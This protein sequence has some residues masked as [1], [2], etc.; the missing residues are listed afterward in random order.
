MMHL[1]LGE[2]GHVLD[3]GLAQVGAVAG[4]E[5]HFGLSL[6]QAFHAGLV[7]QNGLSRLHDQLEP[8]VHGILGLFLLYKQGENQSSKTAVRTANTKN[9]EKQY[10]NDS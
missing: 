6:S 2:H 1:R 3:F 10:K 9:L 8:G 4:N 5:D 7:T